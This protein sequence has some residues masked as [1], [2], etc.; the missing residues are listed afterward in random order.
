VPRRS[1]T[2]VTGQAQAEIAT[3]GTALGAVAPHLR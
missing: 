3:P 2:G 1:D